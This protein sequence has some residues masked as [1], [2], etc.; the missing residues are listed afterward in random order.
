MAHAATASAPP[1]KYRSDTRGNLAAFKQ[2]CIAQFR[3]EIKAADCFV[4]EPEDCP[5]TVHEWCDFLTTSELLQC[6]RKAQS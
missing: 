5:N 3:G 4:V 2:D 1:P 6:F